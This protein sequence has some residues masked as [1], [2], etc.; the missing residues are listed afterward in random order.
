MTDHPFENPTL[1]AI[2][3]VIRELQRL[4]QIHTGQKPEPVF[5]LPLWAKTALEMEGIRPYQ[6]LGMRIDW[7]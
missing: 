6:L 1:L 2:M 7:K 3:N 4:H 5:V